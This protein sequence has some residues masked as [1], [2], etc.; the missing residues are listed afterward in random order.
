MAQFLIRYGELGLKS[1]GVRERFQ[2]ILVDNIQTHFMHH[3]IECRT[4]FDFG[5][6]YLWTGDGDAAK[7]ILARIFGIVSFSEV[8]ET[9]SGLE[10]IKAK[11]A[12][13]SRPVFFQ[14]ARFAVRAR[15]TG[16]HKYTSMELG[17]DVGSAIYLAN[18]K[19][20]PKVDLTSPEIEFFVEVRQNKT[21]IFTGKT[22]GP[23]GMP[24]SSQGKIIG[25]LEQ[26][27]DIA[28]IW[29]MMKRGC[30]TFILTR[31]EKMAENLRIWDPNLKILAYPEDPDI[32]AVG[33]HASRKKAEGIVVGWTL[34]ELE[35]EDNKIETFLPVFHPLVGLSDKEI[36]DIVQMVKKG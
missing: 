13:L 15:R 31:D 4:N 25:V 32:D 11:A 16:E 33:Y 10:D 5:R 23:G 36:A 19:M 6:V 17:R 28:A 2:R 8:I 30:R 9:T 35:L 7:N 1:K 24:L 26:E 18:E 14:G 3:G 29:L 12:E 20:E 22:P 27:K 21:Y 34:P